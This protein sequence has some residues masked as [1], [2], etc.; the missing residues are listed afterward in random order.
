MINENE[1]ALQIHALKNLNKMVDYAWHEIADTLP[2][3]ESFV[4]NPNLPER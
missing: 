1:Q 3:I 4:E 2:K